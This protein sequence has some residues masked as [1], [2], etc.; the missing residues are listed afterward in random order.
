MAD[1]LRT[2]IDTHSLETVTAQVTDG[3][4]LLPFPES[5]FTHSTSNFGIFAFPDA[6]AATKYIYRTLK[7][8][9]VPT[10]ST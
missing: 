7:P 4:D 3:S 2:T 5:I 10:F 1:E 6:I 9:G 8:E